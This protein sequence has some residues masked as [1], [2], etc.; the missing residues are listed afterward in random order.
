MKNKRTFFL[1]YYPSF[2]QIKN[3]Q[4]DKE[5]EF[6]RYNK[7]KNQMSGIFQYRTCSDTKKL[8]QISSGIT[9]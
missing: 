4:I 9:I 3:F 5:E 1:S 7:I 2:L 6:N 8:T